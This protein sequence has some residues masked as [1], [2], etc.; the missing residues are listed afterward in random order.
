MRNTLTAVVLACLVVGALPST[1][2]VATA[3]ATSGTGPK[4]VIIVGPVGAT[5]DAYRSDADAAAAEALR[6]TPNVVK[7]YSPTATWAAA[8]AALQGAS[9]VIYMGHGTGW[10]SPYPPFRPNLM[11]G[12]GLN[13]T[14]GTDDTTTQYWGESYLA[15]DVRLAPNAIVI[16]AHL[17]YSAGNSEPGNPDPTF[18]VA[19]QRVD[20]MAAGW[21]GAGARAVIAEV[22]GE[23][24]YGG[25]AWYV[26]QLFGASQSI[27]Q[28]WRSDPTAHGNVVSFPSVRSPGFSAA[29]DPDGPLAPPYHR[30]IV[31]DLALR[32]A[33]VVAGTTTVPAGGAPTVPP[34]PTPTPMPTP[35]PTP[36]V[37]PTLTAPPPTPTA[38]PWA[39]VVVSD[40]TP[41]RGQIITVTATSAGPLSA[42]PRLTIVQPRLAARAVTMTKVSATTFRAS[43][44]LVAGHTGTMFLIVSGRDRSGHVNSTTVRLPLH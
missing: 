3:A 26:D 30:S 15:S 27:D 31:A 11:D 41:G 19:H 32:T 9:I 17:C 37:P 2:M 33:D 13:P 22:Y 36:T 14:A 6:Y 29:M 23:G 34:T 43:I 25:A 28:V 4:V 38:S 24:L 35:T 39:K 8:K 44:R 42:N 7:V 12:L 10:P 18:A 40:T 5:T 1:G 20:N 16:L 21:I